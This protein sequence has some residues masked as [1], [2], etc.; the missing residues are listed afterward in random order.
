MSHI[1]NT[2]LI[3]VVKK[4]LEILKVP[5]TATALKKYLIQSP[6][7]PSLYGISNTLSKYSVANEA[8]VVEQEQLP[9][10]EP[11]FLTYYSG[12][13]TGKD[14][15]L[16]T[17]MNETQV[18]YYG[19]GDKTRQVSKEN[20]LLHWEKIILVADP[21]RESGEPGYDHHRQKEIN[22]RNKRIAWIVAA[23]VVAILLVVNLYSTA[24]NNNPLPDSVLLLTKIAAMA[25]SV[26]LLVYD[27]DKTSSLVKNICSTGKQTGC[28]AVVNSKA[29]KIFGIKWS[30][31]GFFY[32]A[33]TFLFLLFPGLPLNVKIPFLAL[34]ATAV[35]PYII[36]SVYYQARIA[37]SWCPLCLSIQ[38]I[39]LAEL[40]WAV[41]S[42][43][44]QPV[45]PLLSVP[46]ATG[47]ITSILLP[48]IAWYAFK[49]I[50]YQA[51]DAGNYEAAYKRLLYNPEQ[52]NHLLEQQDT[53]ADGWQQLG[54]D[55]GN[56]NAGITI[57]KVCN[58]YCGP[59]A[60]AHPVLEELIKENK[61]VNVKIIFTASNEE[62]D[63][64]RKPVGHL[65]AIAESG[66][67][68]QVAQALDD[69]YLPA[70]KNYESFA[71]KYPRNGVLTRQGE[72]IKAMKEWCDKAS[73]THTPTF[74]INGKRLPETYRIEE[75][76]NIF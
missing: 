40:V 34:A 65:L 29:G 10:L 57:V 69:W 46:V 3:P 39:L 36:F 25:V 27:Y 2:Q 13:A 68:Q 76:K 4:Y 44:Q 19:E 70:D 6:Y 51:K 21:N 30:E 24:G 26:L 60:K 67:E 9:M 55:I 37:K 53:A 23:A 59:C 72:K 15:I 16:V 66:V 45:A 7:Y 41:F 61:N 64:G 17:A 62:N 58:P 43:W 50:L 38:F 12:Q 48:V 74:F 28:D 32:F 63:K 42:Y 11:P 5:F 56:P 8:F 22:E 52:F 49:K 35:S 31:A 73:I 47:F 18:T 33:S 71:S 1:H 75:L 20:F 14:F 54:I